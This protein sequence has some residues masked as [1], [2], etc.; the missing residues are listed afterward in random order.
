M[1]QPSLPRPARTPPQPPRGAAATPEPERVI[2][3][4]RYL[5]AGHRLAWRRGIIVGEPR[6]HETTALVLV[7]V[8]LERRGRERKRVEDW[9]AGHWLLAC[10]EYNL[11]FL[12][13]KGLIEGRDDAADEH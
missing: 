8:R 12:G 6:R 7:R 10:S 13:G 9:F 2:I 11:A 3:D 5:Y 1:S 4:G